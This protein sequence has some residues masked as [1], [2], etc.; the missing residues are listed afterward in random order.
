MKSLDAQIIK[1][2]ATGQWLS[3][4]PALA[5][6]LAP[7][8]ERP[9]RHVPCPAHG[10]R[11][12]FR[13]FADAAETGGGICNS[14]GSFPDGI[15][16]LQWI[17]GWTFPQT[18]ELIGEYLGLTGE[19]TSPFKQIQKPPYQA[20]KPKD[21][22]QEREWLSRI[23]SETIQDDGTVRRYLEK[24]DL[25]VPIPEAIRLHPELRSINAD[26][27]R[28]GV[29]PTM[30]ACFM[31]DGEFVGLHVT[32]LDP[33]E[34]LKASVERPRKIWKC[35]DS[36]S[37]SAIQLFPHQPDTPLILAE[38]IETALAVHELT[39]GQPVWACGNAVLLERVK[40]LEFARDILIAVDKDLSG[41]GQGA[42][43]RLAE[44]L[45]KEGRAVRF[46]VPPIAIPEGE[47]GV[48]WLDALN[49]NKAVAHAE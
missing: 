45:L 43:E 20:P 15:A 39:N 14:C 37:G 1:Q 27:R 11:D 23:W 2:H 7:A 5:V 4:L 25:S 44:R 40:L 49:A 29:F 16:V 9:G 10:G 42:G 6:E 24:R 48:D 33:N 22:S 34:P 41:A 12:G 26:G 35:V 13:L 19:A 3:I 32:Y 17:N 47:K 8:V 38:G 21:W 46:A 31:R 36:I 18:L 28:E 30:V